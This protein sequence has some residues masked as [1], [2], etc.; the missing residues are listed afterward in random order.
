MISGLKKITDGKDKA[1]ISTKKDMASLKNTKVY[2]T[3]IDFMSGKLILIYNPSL[4]SLKKDH[5]YEHSSDESIAK[6]VGYSLIF[7]NTDLSTV[8]IVRK[9]YDRDSVERAFKQIK[10]VP[11]LRPVRAL[12]KSHIDGH[13]K[14][15]YLAHSILSYLGYV[16]ERK[17]ISG[18]EALDTLRTE[19]PDSH[20][21]RWM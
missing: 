3:G 7:H 18:S 2:C 5:Y 11:D 20:G 14:I 4:E 16:L 12:L 13:V 9:Y 6:Y 21:N 15:Y 19:R 8:E 1:D 17:G 10:G